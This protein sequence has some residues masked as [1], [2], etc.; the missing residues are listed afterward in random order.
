MPGEV[1]G[2]CITAY[3]SYASLHLL[4]GIDEAV[5]RA[6]VRGDLLVRGELGDDLQRQLLAQLDSE[7]IEG[8]DVPDRALHED[9]VLVHGNEHAEDARGDLLD[10]DRVGRAVAAEDLERDDVFVL[11]LRNALGLELG[12]DVLLAPAEGQGLGLREEVGDELDVVV[13]DRIVAD[14]R[15]R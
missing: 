12:D 5:G 6:V 3:V 7:L 13:A 9:L 15:G 4:V 1:P 2:H 8:V 10:Q 14:G 11:L